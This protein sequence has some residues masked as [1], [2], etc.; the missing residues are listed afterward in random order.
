MIASVVLIF[1]MHGWLG[2]WLAD[3]DIKIL[4]AVP[5]MVLVTIFVTVPFVARELIPLMQEQGSE[6]ERESIHTLS[7]AAMARAVKPDGDASP[8]PGASS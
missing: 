2:A 6:E 1:G 5:G 4:F 8:P 3:R 7:V